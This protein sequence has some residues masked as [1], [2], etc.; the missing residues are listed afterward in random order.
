MRVR[1]RPSLG[2]AT[3]LLLAVTVLT[4]AWS[5]EAAG[6]TDGLWTLQIIVVGGLLIGVLFGSAN[7]LPASLSHLLSVVIGVLW[8]GFVVAFVPTLIRWEYTWGETVHEMVTRLAA[9][10]QIVRT[11]GV[12]SDNLIFVLHVGILLWLVAYLAAWTL[13]RLHNVWFAVL[14]AGFALLTNLYYSPP[15][16]YPYSLLFIVAAL[17]LVIRLEIWTSEREWKYKRIGFNPDI[18]WDFLRDGSVFVVGVIALA[19]FT[20]TLS[21]APEIYNQ[22]TTRFEEPL[23]SW[24]SNFNRLFSSL[25]YRPRPGPSYF[26]NTLALSG[27]VNLGDQPIFDAKVDGGLPPR[28]W[29]SVVYD[30]YTGRGWVNSQTSITLLEPGDARLSTIPWEARVPITQ[31][32]TMIQ[33]GGSVVPSVAQPLVLGLGARIEGKPMDPLMVNENGKDSTV[34][35]IDVSLIN[36]NRVWRPGDTFTVISAQSVATVKQLRSSGTEYPAWVTDKYLQVPSTVPPRVKDLAQQITQQYDNPY[37]KATAIEAYLRQ[38]KYN[39]QIASPPAN[40]DLVD[41]FLFDLKEGYCDYYA[42]AF[43][44]MARSIGIPARMAAGYSKGEKIEELGIIRT[45]EY[46]A[47]SW[48]EVFFPK[49]GWIEFEPT[50]S[51]PLVDRVPDQNTDSGSTDNIDTLP[52]GHELGSSADSLSDRDLLERELG[53]S[54]VDLSGLENQSFLPYK[55]VALVLLAL[56]VVVGLAIAGFWA[57]WN[58]DLRGLN[59]VDSMWEQVLRFVRMLGIPTSASLTPNEVAHAVGDAVPE[60][61]E[62]IDKIADV[63]VRQRFSGRDVPSDESKGMLQTWARTQK[64]LW[65]RW[66]GQVGDRLRPKRLRKPGD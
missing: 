3:V 12:S 64:V 40:R 27:A 18:G 8:T 38:F 35:P 49:Y 60:T 63:Y 58:K 29:R 53:G 52:P 62:D 26:S 4:V 61:R 23:N 6:W 39:E 25:N 11:G 50:A 65:R 16:L 14:L 34:T 10:F 42:S 28:Y 59:P 15:D 19:W 41:W 32:I 30:Q 43:N 55:T 24:Q 48:P 20:P 21:A 7:W 44:V 47:H 2:W 33:P 46:D 31:T 22:V 5:I 1:L 9:W 13:F 17:L 57:V 37:D 56:I 54:N 51:D 66:A 36:A 45:H